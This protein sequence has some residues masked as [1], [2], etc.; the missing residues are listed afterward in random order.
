VVTGDS[1]K[2]VVSGAASMGGNGGLK[3]AM[4]YGVLELSFYQHLTTRIW[5]TL[6]SQKPLKISHFY[7]K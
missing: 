5:T 3:I 1:N 2:G 7:Q 4:V 6:G